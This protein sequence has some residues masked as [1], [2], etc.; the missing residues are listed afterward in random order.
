MD[1]TNPY[2][3]ACLLVTA[4]FGLIGFLDDYDKVK[5]AHHA[6]LRARRGWR[7]NS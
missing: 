1:L 5:K 4:G 3:W 2:V 7:S 6:G